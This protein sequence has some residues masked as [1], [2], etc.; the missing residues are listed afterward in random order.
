MEKIGELEPEAA[1]EIRSTG[2]MKSRAFNLKEDFE[3]AKRNSNGYSAEL[4]DWEGFDGHL[5]RFLNKVASFFDWID[6]DRPS[7]KVQFQRTMV[8]LD[9]SG[10]A[11]PKPLRDRRYRAWTKMFDFFKHTSHH[12]DSPSLDQFRERI[13]ELETFLASVFVPKTFDDLDA[14]DALLKEADDA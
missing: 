6:S 8:R 11:L 5:S 2:S 13:E 10:R 3:K 1:E 12:R 14:I 4:G 7:R 9:A